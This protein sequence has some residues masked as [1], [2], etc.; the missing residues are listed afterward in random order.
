MAAPA[1]A[2]QLWQLTHAMMCLCLLLCVLLS[3]RHCSSGAYGEHP[4]CIT[5]EVLLAASQALHF[6][7]QLQ[8]PIKWWRYS[9][10]SRLV[11]L[12]TGELGLWLQV[13]RPEVQGHP[14]AG[15]G[16]VEAA[17]SKP[18]CMGC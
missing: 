18:S 4:E 6:T 14:V 3:G 10:E 7:T 5:P 15:I 17:T 16:Q 1:K 12:G 9:H 13:S 2:L 11:L 8:H